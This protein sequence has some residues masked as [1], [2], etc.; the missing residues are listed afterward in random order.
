MMMEIFHSRSSN[1]SSNSTS[2][3]TWAQFSVQQFIRHVHCLVLSVRLCLCELAEE[4]DSEQKGER[5]DRMWRSQMLAF[6]PVLSFFGCCCFFGEMIFD[7]I[8]F[9]S[10]CCQ[11][12]IRFWNERCQHPNAFD[13]SRS[14]ILLF[15][16]SFAVPWPFFFV[17][18]R[19]ILSPG[20]PILGCDALTSLVKGPFGRFRDRLR[21]KKGSC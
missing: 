21:K 16:A 12:F 7:E 13:T 20:A 17:L 1:N 19:L 10:A 14:S 18:V 8:I 4:A 6:I 3:G 5:T 15:I 9:R 11:I 2:K